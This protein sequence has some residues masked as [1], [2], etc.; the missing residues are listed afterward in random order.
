MTCVLQRQKC[1]WFFGSNDPKGRSE[2]T[3]EQKRVLISREHRSPFSK[4]VGNDKAVRKLQAAAFKAL[5][6]PRHMMRDLAFAIYGPASAGKTTLARLYAEVVE[7]PFC[8]ISPK[9]VRKMDDVFNLVNSVLVPFGVPLVGN[10]NQYRLP[11]CVIFLDEVH[12]LNDNVV[13]GL[14]KATEYNDAVMATETGRILDCKFATWFI[15][16]TDEGRLF[17]AFK[18]RFSPV[19]LNYLTKAEIAR[20][21]KLANPYLEDSVCAL[22]AHYNSRIPRKALEFARYMDIVRMMDKD[23][24]WEEIARQVA[25]DE[26]IDE[27][28]MHDL[29]LRVLKALAGGAVAAKRIP[30][31]V[32]RKKEEVE[33]FIMPVLM[34]STEDQPSLVSVCSRGYVLTDAGVEELRKRGISVEV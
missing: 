29:H 34:C 15:A 17:D 20:I 4:F 2:P 26:G 30:T 19:H 31:I 27:W 1:L 16:T 8:E 22:V 5:S 6:D 12:A 21:V 11:P 25:D 7:L 13:Q 28:G 23:K 3:D 24:S 10:G 32:G 14:L 9:Q 18:T 33:G